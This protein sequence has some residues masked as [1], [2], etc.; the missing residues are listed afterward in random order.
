ME[1]VSNI[2]LISINETLII[3]LIS[4]LIFLFLINRIMFRP[5]R[6]AKNTRDEHLRRLENEI[7]KAN[8]EM[9]SISHE[10]QAREAIVKQEAYDQR[11]LSEKAG[12][13]HADEILTAARAEIRSLRQENKSR[14]DQRLTAARLEIQHQ[15]ESLSKII[16]A[17]LLD[18]KITS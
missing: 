7:S 14:I 17:K 15:A 13:E 6:G 9:A 10:I 1:I 18:R 12:K 3:Q 11:D 8:G 2:A 5:L 4:F 16:M